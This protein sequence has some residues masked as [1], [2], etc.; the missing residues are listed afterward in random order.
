MKMKILAIAILS[1]LASGCMSNT[2][3]ENGATKD[4][5]CKSVTQLEK[6][7][8]YVSSVCTENG[9]KKK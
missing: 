3:I 8:L 1:A 6:G 5:S 2:Y 9:A 7:T 4:S